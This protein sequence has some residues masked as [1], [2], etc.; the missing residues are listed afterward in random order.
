MA[1]EALLVVGMHRSG[2][3]A[4]TRV[5][6]LLGAALPT[7]IMTPRPENET[8]FW[9]PADL[10]VIHDDLLTRAG[11]SWDD[12]RAF[13]RSWFTSDAAGAFHARILDLLRTDL[14]EP[15]LFVIKDPRMCRLVP[16]WL[17]VLEKYGAEPRF[18]MP[19]RHP[20]EVAASLRSRNDFSIQK[21]LLLWLRHV[22]A[23]ERD[24]RGFPR[25]FI[26]YEDLLDDWRTVSDRAARELSIEWPRRSPETERA[27]EEFLSGRHRHHHAAAAAMTIGWLQLAYDRMRAATR[28]ERLA[29][30]VLD[31]LE[32]RL[33]A[34]DGFYAAFIGE[35]RDFLQKVVADGQH[36]T[37][38]AKRL[39]TALDER[40]QV[41]RRLREALAEK[42]G[43]AAALRRQLEERDRALVEVHGRLAVMQ[44]TI[45]WKALE[46]LRRARDRLLPEGTAR[47]TSYERVRRNVAAPSREAGAVRSKTRGSETESIA[48]DPRTDAGTQGPSEVFEHGSADRAPT[49]SLDV[50][51]DSLTA[52]RRVGDAHSAF[53]STLREEASDDYEPFVERPV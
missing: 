52:P 49:G 14:P 25:V 39:E 10:R 6:N 5:L 15:S 32:S 9:E 31:E 7:R 3:S 37:D 47:R 1:R 50:R 22:L 51:G 53:V 17:D 41:A 20:L 45:G 2:T 36:L 8:G 27:I 21:S 42:D 18:V 28:G 26:H 44:E 40:Q 13:P 24:T 23:A 48:D 30:D 33:D 38:E 11:S 19:I 35:E 16:I 34:A 43:E 12:V 4:L 46:R 29:V